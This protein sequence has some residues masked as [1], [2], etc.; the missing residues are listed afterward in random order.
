MGSPRP[1]VRIPP[2][3]EFGTSGSGSEDIARTET[4]SGTRNAY[5]GRR[6][7][8]TLGVCQVPAP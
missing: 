6:G 5:G 3:Q 2:V 7:S 8:S 4:S 1:S